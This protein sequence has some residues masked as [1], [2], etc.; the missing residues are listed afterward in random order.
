MVETA[1]DLSE[2]FAD[3]LAANA[4]DEVR[5]SLTL[6]HQ[7]IV[8]QLLDEEHRM[9]EVAATIETARR[10]VEDWPVEQE[11][12]A[13]IYEGLRRVYKRGRNR[14]AEAYAEPA[15]EKFHKWRKRVKY[16]WYHTRILKPLWP[17][18][19]DELADELHDLSDYL[20]D[21]H[22]L[23]ELRH[24]VIVQP[25]MFADERDL[26]AL[27]ALIDRRRLE[28]EAAARPYEI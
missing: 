6:R 3:L 15:P 7:E 8:A 5:Q 27:V 21:D 13:T 11:D 18:L 9:E 24:T 23:A 4:F 16:L 12:F 10:R 20:G 17:N 19:L 26:Q 25:E 1:D 28:L 2:R 14:L 22:D